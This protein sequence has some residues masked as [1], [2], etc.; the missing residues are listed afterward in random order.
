MSLD[1]CR[2]FL[3]FVSVVTAILFSRD[4]VVNA[5]IKD[6]HDIGKI[7]IKYALSSASSIAIVPA[8]FAR[9]PNPSIYTAQWGAGGGGGEGGS[10]KQMI[11]MTGA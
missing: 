6:G 2:T 1:I 7:C 10:G 8:I 3:T 4:L 5:L 11:Q 9:N